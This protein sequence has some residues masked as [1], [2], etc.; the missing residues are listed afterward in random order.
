MI[1]F[2]IKTFKIW[3]YAEYHRKAKIKKFEIVKN[4]Y[5]KVTKNNLVK[6]KLERGIYFYVY[7]STT[8]I[9]Y[10][11]IEMEWIINAGNKPILL[12]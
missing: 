8:D 12:K 7:T 9:Y 10:A 1:V 2:S 4:Y 11:L 6:T 5:T 3:I